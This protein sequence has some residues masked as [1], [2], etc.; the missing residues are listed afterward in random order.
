MHG[1]NQG[2]CFTPTHVA[3]AAGI[4][5]ARCVRRGRTRRFAPT[6]GYQGHIVIT[7]SVHFGVFGAGEYKIRPFDGSRRYAQAGGAP[8]HLVSGRAGMI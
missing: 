4:V 8:P 2:K 5:V 7:M 6:H 1:V 3:T